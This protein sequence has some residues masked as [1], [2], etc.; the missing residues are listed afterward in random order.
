VFRRDEAVSKDA[1]AAD[2]SLWHGRPRTTHAATGPTPR[3]VYCAAMDDLGSA[4]AAFLEEHRR[5]GE[6]DGGVEEDPAD[7][8]TVWMACSCGAPLARDVDRAG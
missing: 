6:L 3:A 2:F 5:C 1:L 4:L 7:G 8:A